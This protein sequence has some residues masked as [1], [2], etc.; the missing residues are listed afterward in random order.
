LAYKQIRAETEEF[1]N[2]GKLLYETEDPLKRDDNQYSVVEFAANMV[3]KAYIVDVVRIMSDRWEGTRAKRT[4]QRRME[5][6]IRWTGL[7]DAQVQGKRGLTFDIAD[8]LVNGNSETAELPRI[9]AVR[10]TNRNGKP[11]FA[12][13]YSSG[14][15]VDRV[16]GLFEDGLDD[17]E[18]QRGWETHS[19][20]VLYK[21]L[22]N[23]ITYR[24]TEQTGRAFQRAVRLSANR[25][26]LAIPQYDMDKLSVMYKPSKHHSQESRDNIE[27]LTALERTNWLVPQ[28]L[29]AE[30]KYASRVWD[31]STSRFSDSVIRL[32][33]AQRQDPALAKQLHRVA[34]ALSPKNL[35]VLGFLGHKENPMPGGFSDIASVV[36]YPYFNGI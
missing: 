31:D 28:M 5:E 16:A 10:P 33:Q 7:S 2:L 23:Y 24:T 3:I 32:R 15:W 14:K 35:Y 12:T 29:P 8:R 1:A 21:K 22:Y 34:V 27:S 26:L 9:V 25:W 17:D 11:H 13:F 19:F 18:G 30:A 20:R 36:H 4:T 6:Y